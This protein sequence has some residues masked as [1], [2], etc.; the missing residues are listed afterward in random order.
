MIVP[1]RRIELGRVGLNTPP[2]KVNESVDSLPIV[3]TPEVSN[4]VVVEN[5]AIV[6]VAPVKLRL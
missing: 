6:L 5:V 2:E 4:G 1:A 3:N